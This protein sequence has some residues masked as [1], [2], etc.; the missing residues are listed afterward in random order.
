MGDQHVFGLSGE[1]LLMKKKN[2]M[3]HFD[4]GPIPMCFDLTCY[5]YC[6][7]LCFDRLHGPF[8]DLLGD[9]RLGLDRG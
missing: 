9:F 5:Y 2:L 4:F 3:T 1:A 6:R 8:P 7:R